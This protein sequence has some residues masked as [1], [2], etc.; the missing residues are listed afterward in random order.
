MRRKSL[1]F[2]EPWC[3]GGIHGGFFQVDLQHVDQ[4]LRPVEDPPLPT[5]RTPRI[6]TISAR[7]EFFELL[8][9]DQADAN[10]VSFSNSVSLCPK[11]NSWSEEPC[12]TNAVRMSTEK[13][14][15]VLWSGFVSCFRTRGWP[16]AVTRPSRNRKLRPQTGCRSAANPLLH[17]FP[18]TGAQWHSSLLMITPDMS[19]PSAAGHERILNAQTH[20]ALPAGPR[21]MVLLNDVRVWG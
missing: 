18:A 13:V 16:T 15:R 9:G 1:H 14:R 10:G 8:E 20:V 19:A 12:A 7:S 4:L 6:K 21:R 5:G 2:G 3:G 11:R 17:G